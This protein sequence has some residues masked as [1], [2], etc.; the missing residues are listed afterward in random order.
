MNTSSSE[1]K[2]AY[3]RSQVM[4]GT[5]RAGTNQDRYIHQYGQK[6]KQVKKVVQGMKYNTIQQYQISK[7]PKVAREKKYLEDQNAEQSC[8]ERKSRKG[9]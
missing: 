2:T 9:E 1:N 8:G 3:R 7:S 4:G 5:H 6:L